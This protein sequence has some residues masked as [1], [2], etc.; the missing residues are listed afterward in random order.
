MVEEIKYEVEWKPK[1]D[2]T[3]YELALCIPYIF[4]KLH[5][6]EEWDKLYPS[7]KRHF[8]V[9]EYEYGKM[10]KET[11]SKLKEAM[12]IIDELWGDE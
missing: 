2:I 8:K 1:E 11:Q 4:S 3:V 9:K 12:G 10:I 5:S 6:I 7:I